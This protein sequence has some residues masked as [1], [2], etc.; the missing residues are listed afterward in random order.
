MI[1][2]EDPDNRIQNRL[3]SILRHRDQEMAQK[4]QPESSDIS[5]V[6]NISP[7]SVLPIINDIE[8]EQTVQEEIPLEEILEYL[9]KNYQPVQDFFTMV[10]N[11]FFDKLCSD[12]AASSQVIYLHLYR[13]SHGWNKPYCRIGRKTLA[14][15]TN[16]SKNTI[17]RSIKE[18]KEKNYIKE[19]AWDQDGTIYQVLLPREIIGG[20]ISGILSDSIPKMGIEYN[21]IP[22][23]GIPKM[24]IPKNDLLK[25]YSKKEDNQ[26]IEYSGIPKMGIP[27]SGVTKNGIPDLGIPKQMGIP[28]MGI[29]PDY[30]DDKN[31]ILSQISSIDSSGIPKIDP[32]KYNIYK[33]TLSLKT[34]DPPPDSSPHERENFIK[35]II[36]N[37]YR[38]LNQRAS[39]EKKKYG[40]KEIKEL[41]K[42]GF[43]LSDIRFAAEWVAENNAG[44]APKSFS[45]VPHYIDQALKARDTIYANEHAREN[46]HA[47]KNEREQQIREI[48]IKRK[49]EPEKDEGL[50][51]DEYYNTLDEKQKELLRDEAETNLEE[52][53]PN[54]KKVDFMTDFLVRMKIREL[55]KN[56]F[57]DHRKTI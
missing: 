11:F 16:L 10:D 40:E 57:F 54:F 36:E 38:K 4:K 21:S 5:P 52:T 50:Y 49:E 43:S 19:I 39:S 34:W 23:I 45:M 18:L 44:E 26:T 24:G 56:K 15:R 41:L 6:S 42:D 14:E 35:E 46:E 25:E 30:I 48:K 28:K 1:K 37:F 12:L 2:R 20:S 22:K 31:N 27:K 47:R 53:N 8:T 17:V 9:V 7:I 13:L 55:V 33:N 51:L 32:I 3:L 29:P